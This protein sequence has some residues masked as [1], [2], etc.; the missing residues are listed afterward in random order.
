MVQVADTKRMLTNDTESSFLFFFSDEDC[1]FPLKRLSTLRFNFTKLTPEKEDD[2]P[3]VINPVYNNKIEHDDEC[4]LTN[5][6][7]QRFKKCD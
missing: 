2:I 4:N 6:M 5:N 7:T 1:K 3:V